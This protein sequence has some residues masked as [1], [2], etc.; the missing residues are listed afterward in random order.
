[1]KYARLKRIK[2]MLV[3]MSNGGKRRLDKIL[4]LHIF[5]RTIFYQFLSF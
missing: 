3:K 2:K 5:I 1:M 4:T